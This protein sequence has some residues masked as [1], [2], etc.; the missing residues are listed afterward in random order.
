MPHLT[1][2]NRTGLIIAASVLVA[3]GIAVYENP[4]VRQWVDQSRRKIAIALHSLGDE[5]HP[6]SSDAG[7]DD[8]ERRKQ[9]E[10][11][12]YWNRVRDEQKRKQQGHKRRSNTSFDDLVNEDGKLKEETFSRTTAVDEY[13][14]EG[15]LR[16]RTEGVRGMER[17]AAFAN[18]F[19]D[20]QDSQ[21]L[22][23][24]SLVSPEKDELESKNDERGTS[25]STATLPADHSEDAVVAE[26]SAAISPSLHPSEQLIDLTPTTTSSTHDLSNQEQQA[27]VPPYW[28]VN[29]WAESTSPSFYEAAPEPHH[30][31]HN[32]LHSGTHTTLAPS[33][34]SPSLAGSGEEIGAGSSVDG[35]EGR[36][37][38]VL[39]EE[40]G[41]STPGSWT[42]VGSEVS[43]GD[44]GE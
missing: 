32:E 42:E 31:T 33:S 29:E 9:R 2:A 8:D 39:S 15:S 35:E 21:I 16:R 26:P 10:E 1:P 12:L 23:D 41:V 22:V 13:G 38:D 43:E 5:L 6:Q 17:G 4:Q 25:E 28:S 36:Y 3:A 30:E 19:A 11:L 7:P 27:Q 18:P 40:G 34:T 44:H 24:Q 37:L 20:E 14:E